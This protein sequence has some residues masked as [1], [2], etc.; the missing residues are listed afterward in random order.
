M[1]YMLWNQSR[2]AYVTPCDHRCLFLLICYTKRILAVGLGLTVLPCLSLRCGDLDV[3]SSK[4]PGQ[5]RSLAE[6]PF[7]IALV[8]WNI[9]FVQPCICSIGNCRA[10]V[11][12]LRYCA[13]TYHTLHSARYI[14]RALNDCRAKLDNGL[15]NY[16]QKYIVTGSATPVYQFLGYG[17]LFAYAAAWPQVQFLCQVCAGLC[18]LHFDPS[19]A[20]KFRIR[21]LFSICLRSLCC[22]CRNTS[23]SAPKGMPNLQAKRIDSVFHQFVWHIVQ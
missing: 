3:V 10:V 1:S 2:M 7:L 20:C 22:D 4:P 21:Q 15:E 16:R 13:N 6:T 17:F 18:C 14:C 23:T 19:L 8:V 5:A 11:G 9:L 12:F